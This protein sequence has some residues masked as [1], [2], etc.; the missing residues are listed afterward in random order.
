MKLTKRQ[1]TFIRKLLDLYR[2]LQE[3]IPYAALA[4]RLGVSKYTAYYMLRLL[5]KKGY[6]VSKY[7]VR[8]KGPGRSTV[9]FQPT[10]KAREVFNQLAIGSG[11]DWDDIKALIIERIREGKFEDIELAEDI[12]ARI[13]EYLD[14]EVGYCASVVGALATRLRTRARHSVLDYYMSTILRLAERT[15][16][17]GLRLLP[18]F[19]LGL[20]ADDTDEPDLVLELLDNARRYEALVEA[21]DHKARERLTKLLGK[22]LAPLQQV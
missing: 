18:G 9:L 13:P 17:R 14:D 7:K 20:A 2:E 5:D 8:G 21:M 10:Q 19:L 12:L 11:S 4:D 3:P 15:D 6:V 16:L 1:E 22:I